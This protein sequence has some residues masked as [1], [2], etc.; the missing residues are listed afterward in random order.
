MLASQLAKNKAAAQAYEKAFVEVI[1]SEDSHRKTK[2]LTE[3]VE[4]LITGLESP[5]LNKFGGCH[6]MSLKVSM[7]G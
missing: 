3:K 2:T 5:L 1:R 6:L 7:K 4:H